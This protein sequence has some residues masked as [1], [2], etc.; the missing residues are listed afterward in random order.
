VIGAVKSSLLERPSATLSGRLDDYV[1]LMAGGIV[2]LAGGIAAALA[3]RRAA[4]AAAA[5][6]LSVLL[7]AAGPIS[8]ASP[9]IEFADIA[10]SAVRYL[11]PA[12]ACGATAL[13]LASLGRRRTNDRFAIGALVLLG[14]AL[15]WGVVRDAQLG[16]PTVPGVETLV[17]GAVIGA[18]AGWLAGW[19]IVRIPLVVTV[20]VAALLLAFAAH[21]YLFHHAEASR[22]FDQDISRFLAAQPDFADGD[23]PVAAA[24]TMAGALAGDRLTHKLTLITP[25]M[26][27]AQV[28]KLAR[29]GYVLLRAAT[30]VEF[31]G[32]VI[33]PVPITAWKCFATDHP[34]YSRNAASI[35]ALR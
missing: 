31:R 8:G 16:F 26:R 25:H 13:A 10:L 6:L 28:R 15:A 1:S 14:G 4:I 21:N 9:R 22:S 2:L 30:S 27:C 34:I 3:N 11:L 35:Y 32:G 5:T 29:E 23:A 24:P 20:G 33:Y 12:L 17:A 7:W 18:L 19:L